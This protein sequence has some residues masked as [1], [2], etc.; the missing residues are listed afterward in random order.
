MKYVSIFSLVALLALTSCTGMGVQRGKKGQV[1]GVGGAAAGAIIGQAIGHNTGGTLI[2]TAVGGL[3]GYI[4]GNEMDKADAQQLADIA[5]T[6]ASGKPVSWRN[7]DT[8]R[9]MTAVAG[10]AYTPPNGGLCRPMTIR[11]AVP[12]RAPETARV[13]VCRR[14][15]PSTLEAEWVV[16]Q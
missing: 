12:G 7:P 14:I 5:E 11:G 8:G 3:L 1:G 13:I 16:Q 4:F 6:K 2:G 15:N 10:P 9:R